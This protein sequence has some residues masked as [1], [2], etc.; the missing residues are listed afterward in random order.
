MGVAAA[1]KKKRRV[2]NVLLGHFLVCAC[3]I[4]AHVW[5]SH[6]AQ[7]FE[8]CRGLRGMRVQ[9]QG[10][11]GCMG[12]LQVGCDPLRVRVHPAD[13]GEDAS[14]WEGDLSWP[15]GVTYPPLHPWRTVNSLCSGH[16]SQIQCL[17]SSLWSLLLLYSSVNWSAYF[18]RHAK[19]VTSHCCYC[20]Y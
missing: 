10:G 17:L 2:W 8:A 11:G 7:A 18:S 1:E 19:P 9:W 6:V 16:S 12:P 4:C 3:T 15:P 14:F 13:K 20:F 5:V